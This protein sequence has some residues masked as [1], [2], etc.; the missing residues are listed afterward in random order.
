MPLAGPGAVQVPGDGAGKTV[1]QIYKHV[2]SQRK[3][4]SFQ[5]MKTEFSREPLH[6]KGECWELDGFAQVQGEP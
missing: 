1:N 5:V 3:I 6:H 2:I 4:P